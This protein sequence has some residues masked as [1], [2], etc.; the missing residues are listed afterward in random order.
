[1]KEG[2]DVL[3]GALYLIVGILLLLNPIIGAGLLALFV[4]IPFFLRGARQ[5]WASLKIRPE[6]GWGWLLFGGA[7]A[8][9]LGIFLL[10]N[11]PLGGMVAVGVFI[12]IEMLF[13][14]VMLLRFGGALR[15]AAE[16]PHAPPAA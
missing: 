4:A 16:E 13:E 11:W 8:L 5:I 12:G 1:M 6:D 14:G 10:A 9:L 3:A 2:A 15:E 7:L